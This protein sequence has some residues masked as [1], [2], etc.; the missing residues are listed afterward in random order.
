M[1]TKT[2]RIA[3][4]I[5]VLLYAQKA[6]VSVAYFNCP[7][8]LAE[9][10]PKNKTFRNESTA[11]TSPTSAEKNDK[12]PYVT[13]SEIAVLATKYYGPKKN[14]PRYIHKTYRKE[15]QINGRGIETAYGTKPRVGIIAT[16]PAVFPRGTLL[17]VKDPTTGKEEIL[18]AEDKGSSIV[19][20]RIDIFAGFGMKGLLAC[21]K[22]ESKK[23]KMIIAKVIK[24]KPLKK[25]A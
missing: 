7:E 9:F 23:N 12:S 3:A 1:I 25:S 21:E 16:D 4:T 20:K 22:Y 15:V 14:Q 10:A 5:L 19:G 11:I 24:M 18:K 17:L 6:S 13:I 8:P 2:L